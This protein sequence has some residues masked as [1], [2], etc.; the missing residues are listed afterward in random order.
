MFQSIGRGWIF[1][2]QG[3]HLGQ[4]T[5]S[6]LFPTIISILTMMITTIVM[7]LP[8]AGLIIYI[9]KN[10]WG[11]VTIGILVGLLL[12]LITA[13]LN[14]MSVMTANLAGEAMLGKKPSTMDAWKKMS[15]LGGDLY[16]MGLGLPVQR[17]WIAM[18]KLFSNPS[19][20]HRWVDA[21]HLFIPVLANEETRFRQAPKYIEEMQSDNCVFSADGVGIRKVA[22][23]VT[24]VALLT[25][26][27]ASVGVGSIILSS[28]QDASQS[29]ALVFLVA[30]FLTAVFTLPVVSYMIYTTTLFNTCLYLWGRSVRDARRQ[31]S[32]SMATVPDPLAVALGIR[33]GR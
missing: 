3:W 33:T 18:R 9:R 28:G 8:I 30:A 26:L 15:E 22:F 31:G 13:V 17:L 4:K 25:G 10:I 16:L 20:S 12:I 6:V 14:S 21:N 29:R 2:K 27:A 24:G 5:P 11:Q 23:I 32:T 1:V 7:L 19:R